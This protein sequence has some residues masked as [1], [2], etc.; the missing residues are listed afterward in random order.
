LLLLLLL[1]LGINFQNNL[2]YL[3]CCWLASLLVINILYTYRN[4]SG[5]RLKAIAGK[6]C[7]AEQ[8][9]IFEI[10][11]SRNGKA[12]YSIELG[13]PE[14]DWL[15]LDLSSEQNLRIKLSHFAS[16]RGVVKPPRIHLITR[17]PTGL[18]RAWA[19]AHLDLRAIVYP[20]P[21][22][23][24]QL[25]RPN[26]GGEEAEDGIEIA[27]GSS[28]FAGVRPYQPGD[29]PKQIH[30]PVYA[31][32]RE[33]ATREFVDYESHDLWLDFD[34]LTLQG[35]ENRLSHL[36]ARILELHREQKTYGLKVPGTRV[37]PGQG[38]NHRN[39]CLTVL[40]LYDREPNSKAV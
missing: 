39:R 30:W 15:H 12:K 35:T 23:G 14:Q 9:A 16:E 20:K 28:D 40:A 17:Y 29:A 7:F 13:W 27:G 37:K 32:T 36:C 19:Y 1:L 3:F 25:H 10:D 6:S 22:E 31:R 2:V 5:I 24:L 8:N 38:D 11:V 33:L 34:N 26:R 21:R 4:L 18:C